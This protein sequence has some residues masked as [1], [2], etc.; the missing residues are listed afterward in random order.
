M[1]LVLLGVPADLPAACPDVRHTHASQRG[2]RPTSVCCPLTEAR[3]LPTLASIAQDDRCYAL[4]IADV[5]LHV[6]S[7]GKH[8]GHTGTWWDRFYWAP[9]HSAA[10]GSW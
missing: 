3:I 8:Y 6:V 1:A 9:G 2:A 10:G 4:Y 5:S 7:G